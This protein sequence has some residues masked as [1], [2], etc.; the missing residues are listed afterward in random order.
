GIKAGYIQYSI[1][2]AQELSDLFFK[3]FMYILCTAD[4]T[5]RA[6]AIAAVVYRLMCS[7]YHLRVRRKAQ[8]IIGAEVQHL[9]AI[10]HYLGALLRFYYTLFLEQPYIRYFLQ[11]FLQPLIK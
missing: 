10:H 3:P 9:L 8:V 5:H 6:H 4:K 11:L 7:L 1:F 2:R